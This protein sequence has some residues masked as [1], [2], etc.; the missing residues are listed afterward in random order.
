MINEL[1]TSM[2]LECDYLAELENQQTFIKM[3]SSFSY[4]YIPNVYP[5]FTTKHILVSEFVTGDTF[6]Q[7]MDYSQEIKNK[8]AEN[9]F[10]L[11][12]AGLFHF[13]H[14]HTD[15]QD[16][17]YLFDQDKIFLFDFGSIKSFSNNF[18]KYYAL[19]CYSVRNDDK[20]LFKVA[21][22]ELNIIDMDYPESTIDSYFELAG[23]I[24]KPFLNAKKSKLPIENPAINVFKTLSKAKGTKSPD[25][26][27]LLLDRAN[28]GV[29]S[30]IKRLEAEVNWNYLIDKWQTPVENRF[31]KQYKGL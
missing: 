14:L 19:L 21:A 1:K 10:E 31:Y 2:M 23:S 30:K 8:L 24:F 29:F 11:H 27:F 9:L 12:L 7:S 6:D 18:I 28:L 13:N 15:P 26:H 4:L 5:E 25:A 20:E 22:S 3:Y 16:G 17:N